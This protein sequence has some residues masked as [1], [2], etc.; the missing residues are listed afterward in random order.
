MPCLSATSAKI[1]ERRACR[2][3]TG[4]NRFCGP[5]DSS[6]PYAR[7]IP[8]AVPGRSA[9]EDFSACPPSMTDGWQNG[10]EPSG[11]A[12]APCGLKIRCAA[13]TPQPD[14]RLRAPGIAPGTADW[15]TAALL[16]R[17]ARKKLAPAG[18]GCRQATEKSDGARRT[19]VSEHD[20]CW[21]EQMVAL[22][23][24]APAS[25]A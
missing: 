15:Q 20:Q 1:T 11:F 13:I 25:P 6:S 24:I 17:H 9:A 2:T 5:A 21:F 3:R 14:K 4:V 10:V 7:K 8:P 18:S 23:G 16:L 19:L 12:P 22:A